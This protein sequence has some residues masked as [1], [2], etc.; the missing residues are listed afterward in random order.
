MLEVLGSVFVTR[1]RYATDVLFDGTTPEKQ[2][3]QRWIGSLVPAIIFEGCWELIG[4]P[5]VLRTIERLGFCDWRYAGGYTIS[6]PSQSA[7]LFW[8]FDWP[9][10]DHP[11]S[12]CRL[13][14]GSSWSIL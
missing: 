9:G 4:H 5:D 7:P 14:S 2:P 10:W 3:G 6:T 1:L 13:P 12:Y 11:F 8:H